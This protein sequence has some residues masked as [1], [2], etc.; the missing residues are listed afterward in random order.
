M[1]LNAVRVAPGDPYLREDLSDAWLA[2]KPPQTEE[3]LDQLSQAER[4]SPFNAV[5]P[6]TQGRLLRGAGDWSRV[7]DLADRAVALEP[8]YLQARL[9]RAEALLRLGRPAEARSELSEI[10]RRSAALGARIN[11]GAGYEAVI[12][13]FERGNYEDLER[14]VMISGARPRPRAAAR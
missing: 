7:L 10:G 6:A 11:G 3:A 13:G 1:L 14:R 5:Y 4:L 12:L 9:L 8:D 2:Q